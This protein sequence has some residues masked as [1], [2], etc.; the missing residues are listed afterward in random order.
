MINTNT[1]KTSLFAISLAALVVTGCNPDD[2]PTGPG[3]DGDFYDEK[4]WELVWSDEFDADVIDDSKW[5]FEVNCWGGG[6][7]EHQ[8]YVDE[9]DN[10]FVEEGKLH[11]KA[12]R[13]SIEGPVHNP[14]SADYDPNELKSQ[15]FSSARLRSISPLDYAQ[16][17]GFNFRNDWQ[18]G[19]FE[20]R[21]KLPEGQGTWPAIWML[22][23][24][25]AYGGW[26]ASGEIDIM[27]AVNLKADRVIDGETVPE[28]RVH[29]TLHYGATW[30]NNVYSGVEHDFGD[31]NI[32]PADDFHVYTIEWEKGEIRWFID[33]EHFATQTQDG[34]YNHYQQENGDWVEGEADAPYNQ[35]FHLIM[36]L[37]IGGDWAANVNEGGVD[38]DLTEAEMQIDYVRV[39]QCKDD[40][41]GVACGSKG[42]P[43]SFEVSEGHEPP[44]LVEDSLVLFEEAIDEEWAAWDC[45][46][47]TTPALVADVD[48]E[49][50][51]VLQFDISN[52]PEWGGTIVGF[53]GREA[54]VAHNASADHTLEF[55]LK[56]TALPEV[57]D[58]AWIL[59]LESGGESSF[60]EVNLN[61]SEEG[62]SPELNTWQHYTF[63]MD[64]VLATEGHT[65]D[66]HAID[67]VMVAPAW[68]NGQGAQFLIDNVKF[69]K[70]YP[71]AP[72]WPEVDP[73]TGP[74][75]VYEDGINPAWTAW[76]CCADGYQPVE[77]DSGDALY[78]NVVRFETHTSTVAGFSSR[79][80]HGAVAGAPHD[81]SSNTDL[82]F[83]MKMLSH[84]DNGVTN[85]KLKV[86]SNN[87]AEAVEI[88]LQTSLEGEVPA[89]DTWQHYTFPIA[90]LADQGLDITAIDVV[91]VFPTWGAGVG[92]EY[93]LDNVKFD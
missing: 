57:T 65:L 2:D 60:V 11:L 14:D 24:D 73:T 54:G 22:P 6:N 62:V 53:N 79:G 34:W 16:G 48:P 93:L 92:A 15:D 41:T 12:I 56:M 47:G 1:K 78:G 25:W 43:D 29:G 17:E 26:A 91:M 45:C 46:G 30:P 76:D 58:T 20:I 74:L 88:N 50:G 81:A 39:Y 31:I 89:L 75:T 36:N 27:E 69:T 59:K 35:P 33:G 90:D 80:S 42:E 40:A 28:N 23:T 63:R 19:R 70:F 68:G 4:G 72:V 32:N 21:A 82:E 3:S 55:D 67:I 66:V 61:T 49:Y 10:A 52:H 85:W 71:D 83:D 13:E 77:V 44:E 8:C 18:Y 87:G 64:E 38:P 7:N 37:A 9:P 5:A 84:P 51:N 86:E